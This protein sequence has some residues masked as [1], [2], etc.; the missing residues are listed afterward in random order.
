MET[1]C[2]NMDGLKKDCIVFS[3]KFVRK[4]PLEWGMSKIKSGKKPFANCLQM[5]LT[6]KVKRHTIII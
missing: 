1:C 3:D 4:R 6:K 5:G 2:I